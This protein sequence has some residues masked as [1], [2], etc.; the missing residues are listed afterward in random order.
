[1]NFRKLYLFG[2]YHVSFVLLTYLKTMTVVYFN[3]AWFSLIVV[4]VAVRLLFSALQLQMNHKA[5]QLGHQ[6][7]SETKLHS[8]LFLSWGLFDLEMVN[9]F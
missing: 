8:E 5:A 2:S 9:G 4:N 7:L 1:M 6:L 3:C